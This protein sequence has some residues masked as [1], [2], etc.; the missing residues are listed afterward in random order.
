MYVMVAGMDHRVRVVMQGVVAVEL[1]GFSLMC[2]STGIKADFVRVALG[3]RSNAGILPLAGERYPASALLSG[4][5]MSSTPQKPTY[6]QLR[7]R[8]Q[9]RDS[10]S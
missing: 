5:E 9:V 4:M 8:I 6:K 1:S 3:Q 7:S 10:R 2:R